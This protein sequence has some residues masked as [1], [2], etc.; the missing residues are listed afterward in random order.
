MSK[1]AVDLD[2]SQVSNM[3]DD[4]ATVTDYEVMS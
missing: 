4:T 3:E 2:S 1:N